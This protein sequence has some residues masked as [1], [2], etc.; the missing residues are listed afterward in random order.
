MAVSRLLRAVAALV[1]LVSFAA[2]SRKSHWSGYM[3]ARH[4]FVSRFSSFWR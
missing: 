4:G 2:G 3:K 1:I